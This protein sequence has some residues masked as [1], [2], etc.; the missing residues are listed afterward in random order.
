[1]PQAI[2]AKKRK[3][4]TPERGSAKK[5]N[6]KEKP[7]SVYHVKQLIQAKKNTTTLELLCLAVKQEREGKT[8]LGEFIANRGT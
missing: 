8:S 6:R 2:A 1:M 5:K 3:G 7:L 4:K